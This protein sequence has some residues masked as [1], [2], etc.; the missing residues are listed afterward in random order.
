ML[1]YILTQE[2]G[3]F[4]IHK[5]TVLHCTIEMGFYASGLGWVVIE[6]LISA[7]IVFRTDIQVRYLVHLKRGA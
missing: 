3:K 1:G 4:H 2:T 6:D 5:V 7:K